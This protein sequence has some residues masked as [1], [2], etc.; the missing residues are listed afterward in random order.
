MVRDLGAIRRE[1]TVLSSNDQNFLRGCL[2]VVCL[3]SGHNL[4][5]RECASLG[6]MLANLQ[7]PHFRGGQLKRRHLWCLGVSLRPG[8]SPQPHS[9]RAAL[10][11][12]SALHN[13]SPAVFTDPTPG[14][15]SALSLMWFWCGL[16]D[17]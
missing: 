7:A 1:Q 14:P 13:M 8:G 17:V 12:I 16:P 6:E 9:L 15:C 11:P 5:G 3:G 10:S 4:I 2:R